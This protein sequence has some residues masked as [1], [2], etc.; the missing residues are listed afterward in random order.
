[1]EGDY[2]MNERLEELK[3]MSE[4]NMQKL[5]EGKMISSSIH[6]ND[7]EYLINRVEEL[8]KLNA[9][10]SEEARVNF[11][12]ARKYKKENL[13][14]KQVF[15]EIQY[16]MEQYFHDFLGYSDVVSSIDKTLKDY[17]KKKGE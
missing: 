14:Y 3:K 15:G 8:E 4:R 11:E 17:Y 16:V 2:Q 7:L 6:P 5:R 13:R 10:L 1:M 9:S 12:N